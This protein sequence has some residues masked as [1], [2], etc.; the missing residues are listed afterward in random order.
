MKKTVFCIF[1]ALLMV[2]SALPIGAGAAQTGAQSLAAPA[3]ADD[4]AQTGATTYNVT[5]ANHLRSALQTNGDITVNVKNDIEF[6]MPDGYQWS[7]YNGKDDGIAYWTVIAPGNKTINLNGHRL[8]ITDNQITKVKYNKV[9][10]SD[11]S[12]GSYTLE[13]LQRN[14][15]VRE[16]FMFRIDADATLTVNGYWSGSE[17]MF[18]AQMPSESQLIDYQVVTQRSLFELNGGRLYINGGEYQAGR[19]KTVYVSSARLKTED[20][21]YKEGVLWPTTHYYGNGEYAIGGCVVSAV[22]GEAYI[23][24]GTLI[25]HGF[26]VG[27]NNWRNAVLRTV[28]GHIFM[29]DG[30]LKGYCGAHAVQEKGMG[31]IWIYGGKATADAREMYLFPGGHHALSTESNYCA[32]PVS[33]GNTGGM[34]APY[35]DEDTKSYMNSDRMVEYETTYSPENR[36][37]GKPNWEDGSTDSRTV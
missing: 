18:D 17:V 24:G 20:W 36:T 34:K 9:T 13:E 22:N 1:L 19:R 33:A 28:D 30:T 5:D 12:G 7:Q 11:P 26:D 14:G 35:G 8:Y 15:Y 3:A 23:S 16:A 31:W 6:T 10:Y 29:Y 25:A 37:I 27:S 4:L 2:L 21:N 32:V